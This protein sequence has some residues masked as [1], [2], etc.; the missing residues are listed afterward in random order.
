MLTETLV[1]TEPD[2]VRT[3]P[4]SV[5]SEPDLVRTEPNVRRSRKFSFF[6]LFKPFLNHF[7]HNF[8]YWR[9]RA[10]W[11]RFFTAFEVI[12]T[13]PN[14]RFDICK[15]DYMLSITFSDIMFMFLVAMSG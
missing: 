3:E 8:E 15:F 11:G 1:R 7:Q 5:R 6:P 9:P 2:L 4:D 13:F 12:L 14:L 10:Y